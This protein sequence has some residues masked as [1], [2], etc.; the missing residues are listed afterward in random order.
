MDDRLARQRAAQGFPPTVQDPGVLAL[1]AAV[2]V[3]DG[4]GAAGSAAPCTA[5]RNVPS[6]GTT[7]PAPTQGATRDRTPTP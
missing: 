2:V 1:V 7:R 3:G 4:E 5:T 6:A